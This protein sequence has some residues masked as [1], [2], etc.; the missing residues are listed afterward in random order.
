MTGPVLIH[1]VN[2]HYGEYLKSLVSQAG[3]SSVVHTGNVLN[4]KIYRELNPVLSIFE[5]GEK[6]PAFLRNGRRKG[7]PWLVVSEKAPADL[8][9]AAGPAWIPKPLKPSHFAETVAD[10]V[11]TGNGGEVPALLAEPYLIGNSPAIS[12]TRR[13]VSRISKTDLAVLICGETGTGKGLVAL[14]IHNNSNRRSRPFLEVNCSSI[15]SSLLESELFGYKKGSFTGA[16]DDKPGRFTLAD[17]GTILLDEIA[18]MPHAMQA[19][20]LQVLQDGEFSPLGGIENTRVNVRILS[21]T[22]APLDQLIEQQR[23]RQDLY[24][25]LKVIHIHMPP[26]RERKEDIGVLKEHFLEKY[27][28]LYNKPPMILSRELQALLEAYDWPGNVRELEN[29]LKSVVALG[30][31]TL[32]LEDLRRKC[33]AAGHRQTASKVPP[34]MVTDIR[35]LSLKEIAGKVA[36]KAERGAIREALARC[37]G[38]KKATADLLNVSYKSL[39]TKIKMYGLD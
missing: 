17:S 11:R 24:F 20:L 37:D 3:F 39:L 35:N 27:S 26:L 22:N 2:F 36:A 30:N 7:L 15:P 23:F 14:A 16:W 21:A 6:L 25:R 12:E 31:E 38:N 32:A 10:R 5:T 4:E 28:M 34:E 29:C 13:V 18:E 8:P 19:K 9:A 33:R 1:A